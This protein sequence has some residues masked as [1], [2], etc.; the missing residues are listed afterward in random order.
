M[1]RKLLLTAAIALGLATTAQAN[2]IAGA[3]YVCPSIVAVV[4]LSDQ[5]LNVYG[6]GVLLHRWKVS[7]ARR[8]NITPGW[9]L[10]A[11]PNS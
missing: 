3:G 2:A 4:D 9:E 6:A 10:P 8:E 1:F 11:L 7:T 5:R